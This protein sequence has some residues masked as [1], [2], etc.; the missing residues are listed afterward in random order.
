MQQPPGPALSISVAQQESFL[1]PRD[2]VTE[3]F[4]MTGLSVYPG[5]VASQ[6]ISTRQ[7]GLCDT[8]EFTLQLSSSCGGVPA[9]TSPAAQL[10]HQAL[11]RG[12][13]AKPAKNRGILISDT[14]QFRTGLRDQ[15][16]PPPV[17]I[18]SIQ[19]VQ[20]EQG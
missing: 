13:A 16:G 8:T 2:W 17:Y 10:Q 12:P 19:S 9:S 11:P 5:L 1:G 15:S 7:D 6:L 3:W 14:L 20:S 4:V 18:S